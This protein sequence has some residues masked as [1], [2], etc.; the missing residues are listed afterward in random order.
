MAESLRVGSTE[1]KIALSKP[2]DPS[3]INVTLNADRRLEIVFNGFWDGHL[4]NNVMKNISREY[5]RNRLLKLRE[6]SV[7]NNLLEGVKK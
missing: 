1:V 3:T 6:V 2:S 5:R 7:A 4:I